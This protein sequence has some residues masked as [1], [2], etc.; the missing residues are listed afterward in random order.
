M[1]RDNPVKTTKR[2]EISFNLSE[3]TRR[4]AIPFELSPSLR[5]AFSCQIYLERCMEN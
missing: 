3:D 1:K 5:Y 2:Y 4:E